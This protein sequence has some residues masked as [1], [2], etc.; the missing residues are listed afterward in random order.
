[1]DIK[2]NGDPDKAKKM[3][4]LTK[5]IH[6]LRNFKGFGTEFISV[7]IPASAPIHD[8]SNKLKGEAG[9]ASNIKSKST[10]KNVTDSLERI[11]HHLKSYG[12]LA[13]ESGVAIFCG[14]ISDNPARTDIELFTVYPPEPVKVQIYR[15]DSKFFLDPLEGV[16]E[17]KESYGLVVLDGRECTIASLKGTTIT[18]LHRLNSTAHAKIRKGGQSAARYA[19]LIEEAI[20]VYY[21]RIGESMDKYFVNTVKGV[22]VGGPGPAK[23]YF[24]KMNPFNYQIKIMGVVDTGYT[25]EHG[26]KEL[27]EKSTEI[28]AGQQA[29]VERELIDRF[30]KEVV[31][32]G[33]AA[34]GE[35]NVRKALES[36]QAST[37]IISEDLNWKRYHVQI[38]GV[39]S[40]I[41]KRTTDEPPKTTAEGKK[42]TVL[43]EHDL[44]DDLIELADS[45]GVAVKIV[46]S[47]TGS[48]AQ[49]A[50]S[51][52][53][54]GVFLRYR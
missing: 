22:I 11:I 13:P 40:F 50:Q 38:D 2:K 16:L 54:M 49:F 23:E 3:Y 35:A 45:A 47:E 32:N 6:H 15:C 5:Q 41:N 28:I 37:L 19:R 12:N 8:T 9:Q 53:G 21:K 52:Y 30:I 34:Y 18:I 48:G 17:I 42:I 7:Y 51:F 33:L 44:S 31:S 39:E 10:R 4:L 27:M 1:M 36:K 20:E 26:L 14:N 43:S 46:S 29:I 24:I 25:E